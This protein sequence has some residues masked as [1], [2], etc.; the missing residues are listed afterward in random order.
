MVSGAPMRQK[1]LLARVSLILISTK[2]KR[3]LFA[4]VRFDLDLNSF[5]VTFGHRYIMSRIVPDAQHISEIASDV[6]HAQ[7]W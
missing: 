6:Y 7:Q 1:V 2:F 3:S 4:S 5:D